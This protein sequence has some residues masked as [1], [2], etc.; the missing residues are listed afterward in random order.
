M[1]ELIER[2]DRIESILMK[3]IEAMAGEEDDPIGPWGEERSESD[4]L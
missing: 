2:L 4:I 1:D 3:L